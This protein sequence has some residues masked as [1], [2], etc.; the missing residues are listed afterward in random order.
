LRFIALLTR[1]LVYLV[2]TLLGLVVLVFV[3]ANVVPADPAA[4][5]AGPFADQKQIEK[6]RK[7]YGFD[8]PVHI[9]LWMYLKR[10]ARGDLGESL[11][12]HRDI[13]WEL[14]N[15]FPATLELT[16]V[17]LFMSV[18]LGIPVGIFSAIRRN[19]WIDHV[20]RG[21]TIAGLAIAAFW[22]G[23]ELQ[24]VFGYHLDLFP[25]S[26]RITGVRPEEITHLYIL[27][28]ILTWNWS[29]LWSS[30]V[31]ITLP[32]ATLVFTAFAT[33][34]RFTRAGVLNALNSDYVLYERAMGM[35]RKLLVYKYVLRNAVTSTITQIGLLFG[36][37]LAGS[38]V[39]ERVFSWPGMGSFAVESILMMD[40]AAVLGV[41]LWAGVA[42]TLGNLFVDILLGFVDP[43]E[44]TR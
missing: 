23:I 17:S 39:I 11:Y 5:A 28:S 29:S 27:D 37:L 43:R 6:I 34:V 31:H 2:P 41:A 9:Q 38:V 24:L 32:A 18:V 22:L 19:A 26:G 36:Y 12:T 20:L 16:L 1:R 14:F 42:Y 7:R 25:I 40:Y 30:L 15:R 33:L 21:I 13:S 10:L 3:I 8:Q 35:P 44:T 4:L